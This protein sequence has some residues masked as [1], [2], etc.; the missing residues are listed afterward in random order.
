[1]AGAYIHTMYVV[2]M[3]LD[4]CYSCDHSS[5]V[6]TKL[7]GG[8]QYDMDYSQI[9]LVLDSVMRIIHP[10]FLGLGYL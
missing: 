5:L 9:I 6:S 3:S 8:S 10:P 4:A 2:H 1:M 7:A